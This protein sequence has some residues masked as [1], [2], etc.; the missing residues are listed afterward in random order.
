MKIGPLFVM[1]LLTW[2]GSSCEAASDSS[3]ILLIIIASLLLSFNVMLDSI[4]VVLYPSGD[5]NIALTRPLT[6][7]TTVINTLE[8]V[9]TCYVCS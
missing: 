5:A 6:F 4:L 2:Y 7:F 3:L 1:L 9:I 8:V